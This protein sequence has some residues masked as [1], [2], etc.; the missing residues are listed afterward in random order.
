MFGRWLVD[1]LEYCRMSRTEFATEV[2]SQ[3]STVSD[4]INGKSDPSARAIARIASVLEVPPAE[5]LAAIVADEHTGAETRPVV[6]SLP[7]AMALGEAELIS[8]IA[9]AV[10]HWGEDQEAQDAAEQMHAKIPGH[11]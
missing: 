7:P 4:W 9:W 6:P 11:G 3:K 1:K 5:V 8:R 2:K 10:R